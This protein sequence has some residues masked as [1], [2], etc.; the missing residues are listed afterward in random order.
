MLS[1]DRLR[2]LLISLF[3]P[4]ELEI[5]LSDLWGDA[6]ASELPS[7]SQTKNEY[8]SEIV[9]LLRR[10]GY[11]GDQLF[12]AM[13]QRRPGREQE[14]VSCQRALNPITRDSVTAPARADGASAFAGIPFDI[15]SLW[16]LHRG[17]WVGL[18]FGSAE[19]VERA[20]RESERLVA[21]VFAAPPG[22]VLPSRVWLRVRE[23]SQ[24]QVPRDSQELTAIAEPMIHGRGGDD[25]LGVMVELEDGTRARDAIVWVRAIARLVA[26][27]APAIV[28]TWPRDASAGTEVDEWRGEFARAVPGAWVD[29]RYSCEPGAPVRATAVDPLALLGPPPD[30]A[31]ARAWLGDAIGALIRRAY[32][33]RAREFQAAWPE[34]AS[35]AGQRRTATSV[36]A[37]EGL[38]STLDAL[39]AAGD[40]GVVRELLDCSR[41]HAEL[42]ARAIVRHLAARADEGCCALVDGFVLR[43]DAAMDGWTD[44]LLGGYGGQVVSLPAT[45]EMR[46]RAVRLPGEADAAGP[47]AQERFEVLVLGLLRWANSGGKRLGVLRE[48]LEAVPS[49][50]DATLRGLVERTLA[51]SPADD[52]PI[53][54]DA[55]MLALRAGLTAP[56]LDLSLDLRMGHTWWPVTA[57]PPSERLL[58]SVRGLEPQAR[59]ILGLWTG[60]EREK[61][62]SNVD[63]QDYAA[64]CRRGACLRSS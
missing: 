44:A 49:P 41:I 9:H 4:E 13:R 60:D 63:W 64:G 62:D 8:A 57:A 54:G 45:W 14:I 61:F 40:T 26:T 2:A 59:G 16:G 10:H 52:T 36:R 37:A 32:T 48:A 1:D 6:I 11:I 23:A 30:S 22:P 35:L 33:V 53:R 24:M 19:L 7:L 18:W 31:A 20:L 46:L 25:V 38:E 27:R 21:R 50:T 42:D 55:A 43:C 56:V 17:P 29:V 34:L 12:M 28:L 58:S 15:G 39:L 51:S 3:K 47:T 5:L